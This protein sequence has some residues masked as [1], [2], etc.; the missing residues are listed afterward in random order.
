MKNNNDRE[1]LDTE[2]DTQR[3]WHNHTGRRPHHGRACIYKLKHV[4]KISSTAFRMHMAYWHFD[5]RP[6][7]LSFQGKTPDAF[8]WVICGT[9]LQQPLAHMPFMLSDFILIPVSSV[10]TRFLQLFQTTYPVTSKKIKTRQLLPLCL[11]F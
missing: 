4:Q 3:A 2:I 6:L 7:N 1:I 9:L 5:F 8:T 11:L 10:I